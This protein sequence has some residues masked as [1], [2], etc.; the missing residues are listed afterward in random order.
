MGT[1]R[2]I[3]EQSMTMK[4]YCIRYPNTKYIYIM[5][6]RI[7]CYK[8]KYIT[9]LLKAVQLQY[10]RVCAALPGKLNQFRP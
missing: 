1:F 5:N 3:H 8:R 7:P 4:S 6:M 9:C 2:K 10:E